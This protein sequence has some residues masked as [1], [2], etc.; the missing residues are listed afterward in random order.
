MR[1]QHTTCMC[2][3]ACMHARARGVHARA[4]AFKNSV[5][6]GSKRLPLVPLSACARV[7]RFRSQCT[8]STQ[9]FVVASASTAASVAV[10]TAIS[11]S[12]LACAHALL[13]SSWR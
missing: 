7:C 10:Q 11:V 5:S 8:P 9:A 4:R 2:A 12:L 1:S 13:S 3:H 6:L